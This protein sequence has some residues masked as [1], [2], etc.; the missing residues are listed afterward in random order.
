MGEI[1]DRLR[2]ARETAGFSSAR[3]AAIKHGWKPSTYA[4]HENGQAKDLS[5]QLIRKYALVF[6]V[7][8]NW[9]LRGE[10]PMRAPAP[11]AKSK[12]TEIERLAK[13]L[14]PDKQDEAL[15]YLKYLSGEHNP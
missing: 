14:P 11:T 1:N 4:S 2:K 9:L 15:N 6:K 3:S 8:P 13:G 10:E 5:S 12:A 7:N